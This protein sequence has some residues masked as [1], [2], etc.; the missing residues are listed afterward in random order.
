M[1]VTVYMSWV[2]TSRDQVEVTV[3][4]PCAFERL[5]SVSQTWKQVTLPVELQNLY[6]ALFLILE[7]SWDS[8]SFFISAL[9][10][11]SLLLNITPMPRQRCPSF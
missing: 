5:D 1:Y 7:C 8:D 9:G 3:L 10:M 4:L 2:Y 11:E 6:F